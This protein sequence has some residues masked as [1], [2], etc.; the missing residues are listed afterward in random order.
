MH[1]KPWCNTN[2]NT[3]L[4]NSSIILFVGIRTLRM[5]FIKDPGELLDRKSAK[6]WGNPDV[7][8][9]LP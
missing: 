5:K 8:I 1:D 2:V 7:Y 6:H 4:S 9:A 3:I